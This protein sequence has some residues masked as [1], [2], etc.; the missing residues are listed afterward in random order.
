MSK[1]RGDKLEKITLH[2]ASVFQPILKKTQ[3]VIEKRVLSKVERFDRKAE[4]NLLEIAI[5]FYILF[6]YNKITK[7]LFGFFVR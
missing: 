4:T 7:I 5:D 1:P 3:H 6:R 2:P